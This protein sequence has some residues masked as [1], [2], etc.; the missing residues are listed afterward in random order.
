MCILVAMALPAAVDAQF[1][2]Q[3]EWND[4][5]AK[6]KGQPIALAVHGIEGHEAVV[7]EFHK[8]F[9][10]INVQLTVSNPSMI[11]PRIVTEQKNGI[12]AW[13][14]WWA[15]TANMNNVVLPAGGLDPIP[16]YLILPE[17]K[18]L[19][20][21]QA[22]NYLYTS[23]KGPFV[24][25]H[26]YYEEATVYRNK[27][28]VRPLDL[29]NADQLLDR[30]LRGQIA[31]RDPS[32]PNSGSFALAGL[33]KAKGLDFVRQLFTEM[34]PVVID[35]PRQLTDAVLRGDKAVIIGAEQD[36]ITRCRLAG[37]CKSVVRLPFGRYMFSRGVSVLKNAPHKEAT[38]VWIN[39]LLSRDG[40]ETYVREWAKT[41]DIGA[42]SL[43]KDV[44]PQPAQEA[45]TPDY[46]RM[47]E[48]LLA[49]TDAGGEHLAAVIKLYIDLRNRPR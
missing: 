36:L 43:R 27:D 17:V 13:D 23:D 16:N 33:A 11:A 48:Y 44:K 22:P 40:Q 6:A 38:K 42:L 49:G 26:T 21:W 20:N 14:S 37:G 1:D 24:F 7:R 45:A 18:D 28:V 35:N 19:S 15:A 8:K 29:D 31:I 4:T 47:G 34:A 9:P 10:D 32:R 3:R 39:W 5:L 2:W 25:V 41:N 30:R 12:F 46:E